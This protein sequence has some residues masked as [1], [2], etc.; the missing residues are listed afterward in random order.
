MGFYLGRDLFN[1][2]IG[3]NT[4]TFIPSTSLNAFGRPAYKTLDFANALVMEFLLLV[5]PA[6]ESRNLAC[7]P[8]TPV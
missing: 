5:I 1:G 3:G 7:G 8:F 6:N 2:M 4:D